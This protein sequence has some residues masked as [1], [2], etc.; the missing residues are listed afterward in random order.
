MF[1]NTY[2][3]ISL[4]ISCQSADILRSRT[5]S[6]YLSCIYKHIASQLSGFEDWMFFSGDLNQKTCECWTLMK[7]DMIV[8][9]ICN[10]KSLQI[11]VLIS[12]L[13]NF[14]E[15]LGSRVPNWMCIFVTP[16]QVSKRYLVVDQ[17]LICFYVFSNFISLGFR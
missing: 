3:F 12:K 17:F 11:H 14:N 4:I 13:P 5:Y 8:L 1:S 9:T 15:S 6:A 10:K 16:A 2:A 7:T